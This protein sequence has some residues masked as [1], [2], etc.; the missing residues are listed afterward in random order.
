MFYTWFN[1]YLTKT[2]Y[3]LMKSIKKNLIYTILVIINIK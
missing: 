3:N 2:N 1:K